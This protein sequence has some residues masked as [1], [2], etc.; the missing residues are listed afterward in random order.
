MYQRLISLLHFLC[1]YCLQLMNKYVG[2]VF[3][4]YIDTDRLSMCL[5]G[6]KPEMV[7]KFLFGCT[8]VYLL[9]D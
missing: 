6:T 5:G 2:K 8:C 9:T 1:R 3:P 4:L 7:T